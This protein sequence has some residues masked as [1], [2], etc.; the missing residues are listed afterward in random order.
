MP[1]AEETQHSAFFKND[2]LGQKQVFFNFLI[3]A[4]IAT[5]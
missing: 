3:H 2:F 1:H 4:G 5:I